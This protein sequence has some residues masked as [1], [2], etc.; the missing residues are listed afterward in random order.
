MFGLIHSVSPAGSVYL[1]WRLDDPLA[2]QITLGYA[3]LAAF[4]YFARRRPAA[5][6]AQPSDRK[7][8]E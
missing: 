7:G 1:P 3:L 4:L 8:I 5:R 2:W 6:A